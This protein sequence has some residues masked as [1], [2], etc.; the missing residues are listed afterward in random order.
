MRRLFWLAMGITIGAL[1]V[2][3]VS[4]AAQRVNPQGMARGLGAG[5][6][7][8]TEAVRSFAT[9]VRDAMGEREAELRA[10]VGLDGRLGRSDDAT[11]AASTAAAATPAASKSVEAKPVEDAR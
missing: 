6:A 5:L 9:D 7:N 11:P 8:L 4:R 3:K 10:G 1:V 2:R